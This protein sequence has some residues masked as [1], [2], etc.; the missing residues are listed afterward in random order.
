MTDAQTTAATSRPTAIS[1]FTGCG[2][3][4]SGLR[5][6]GFQILFANDIL[7]YAKEVYKSN[8]DQSNETEYL[9]GDVTHLPDFPDARLLVG[10]Y[11]C[12]GFCQG[13]ARDPGSRLNWLYM[14]FDR[15]L[16]QVNPEAFIVENVPGMMRGRNRRYFE[17]Q[18]RLFKNAGYKLCWK[19][20][21]CRDYGLAQERRRVFIVGIHEDYG[22]TYEF[23]DPTHGPAGQVPYNTQRLVLG[24]VGVE[25]PAGEFYDRAFHWYYLS[26]NR[27]RGWDE[28]SKTVLANAR[29]MPLHPM[30]PPLRKE[31]P[32]KWVFEGSPETARRLSFREA[33]ALQ[34]MSGWVFPDSV[35]LMDK[36]KVIGNAVPPIVFEQIAR[37]LPKEI[38][39]A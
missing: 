34:N 39:N 15:V 24:D 10:C 4:D 7:P 6:A 5:A 21:D 38:Q 3:S 22:I 14:Q 32:D 13:G 30:S 20:V 37:A 26:R 19:Q 29:H 1:L 31:G 35:G 9:L 11:P 12:Q 8:V 27:Y 25:W 17:D 36:Y 28:Q 33:A 2:G 23:P 18:L 16:R